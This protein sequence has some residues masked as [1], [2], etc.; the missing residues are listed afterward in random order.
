MTGIRNI[1]AIFTSMVVLSACASI[2]PEIEATRNMPSTASNFNKALQAEYA[3][4]AK[5]E[6]DEGD[7]D[8]AQYFIDKAKMAAQGKKVA[9]QAIAER[10]LPG[11]TVAELEAARQALVDALNA[12]GTIKAPKD[13]A[14]AQAMFD[15]WIEEQ[16][17]NIQP[18][19]IAACRS[20]FFTALEKVVRSLTPETMAAKPAPK[21]APKP[22][23]LPPVPGP[24]TVFFAFDSSEVDGTGWATITEAVEKAISAKI[25]RININGHADRSG[26]NAYNLSLSKARIAA[27]ASA[28]VNVGLSLDMITSTPLGEESPIVPT[29]DGKREAKNRRVDI[30]FGR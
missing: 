14:H 1:L 5:M 20:P 30:I 21:A 27:V 12:T 9:P 8:N 15:C 2:A 16:H 3:I 10:S 26:A 7:T 23:P 28:L 24:Y 17:E 29:P 6:D 4:I 19:D 11:D 18:K 13:A 25:T 22:A